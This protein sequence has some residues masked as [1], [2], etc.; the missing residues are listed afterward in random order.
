MPFCTNLSARRSYVNDLESLDPIVRNE[1]VSRH[2][3][4]LNTMFGYVN[5]SNN[6]GELFSTNIISNVTVKFETYNCQESNV[7]DSNA[8]GLS[9]FS[10]VST[11]S[12]N[13]DDDGHLFF[14]H[15]NYHRIQMINFTFKDNSCMLGELIISITLYEFHEKCMYLQDLS[16]MAPNAVFSDNKVSFIMSMHRNDNSIDTE[17][18]ESQNLFIDNLV[19]SNDTG[20]TFLFVSNSSFNDCV[21]IINYECCSLKLEYIGYITSAVDVAEYGV[22]DLAFRNLTNNIATNCSKCA[23]MW[24]QHNESSRFVDDNNG[25]VE[26]NLYVKNSE[27]DVPACTRY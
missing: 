9:V 12:N 22:G 1:D 7:N 13:L 14:M 18:I 25:D 24:T 4:H 10:N 15:L 19:V 27:F 2:L 20:N 3:Q 16:I 21:I 26:L 6:N 11:W 5:F 23:L 8:D 17:I